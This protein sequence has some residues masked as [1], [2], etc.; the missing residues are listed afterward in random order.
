[1]FGKPLNPSSVKDILVISLSNI[2][3]VVLICPVIDV[4]LRDFTS[5]S[6]HVIVGPKAS[7]LL[8][9]HPR[10]HVIVY[11]K[12]MPWPDQCRWFLGLRRERFDLIVDLRNTVLPFLLNARARTW[13]QIMPIQGHLRQKHLDRLRSVHPFSDENAPPK[14]IVPQPVSDGVTP[15]GQFA[16]IASSA[17]DSAKRWT[18]EGFAQAADFIAGKGMAVV[19]TGGDGDRQRIDDIRR[20]MKNPSL[21][22]AGQ[23]NLRELAFVLGKARFAV[24]HDSGAMHIAGYVHTPVIALFGPTDEKESG[25]Q[26]PRSAVVRR[27]AHCPRCLDP[28]ARRV[29]HQCMAAIQAQDVIDAIQ[30]KFF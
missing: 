8:E 26:D 24:V 6:V 4:L 15:A 19:F 13:P 16:V 2:G 21:S 28:G 14:A 9:G 17:A 27:N 10:L 30:T 5:A 29:A 22:L 20:R 25:P 23:L 1:M 7:S 12:H 3:D 18:V 11:D